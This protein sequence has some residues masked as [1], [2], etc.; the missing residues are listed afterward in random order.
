M[1]LN[2]CPYCFERMYTTKFKIH[3]KK[4]KWKKRVE[5]LGLIDTNSVS[6]T[7]KNNHFVIVKG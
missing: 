4:C 7:D 6:I 2:I 3:Y 1:S 5:T